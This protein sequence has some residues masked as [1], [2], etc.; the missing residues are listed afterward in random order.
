EVTRTLTRKIRVPDPVVREIVAFL[1]A[2]ASTVEGVPERPP[3]VVR[4]PDDLVILGGALSGGADVLVTGD[5]DLLVL[6][7]VG[8]LRILNPRGFWELVRHPG[9]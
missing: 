9:V 7:E 2:S 1:R 6:G 8:A 4:D 5:K 3:I